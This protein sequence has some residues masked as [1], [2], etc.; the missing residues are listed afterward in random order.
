MPKATQQQAWA[1]WMDAP[2]FDGVG[3]DAAQP[4]PQAVAQDKK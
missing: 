1:A 4:A 2:R 3:I